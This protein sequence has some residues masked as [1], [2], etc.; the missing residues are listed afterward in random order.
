MIKH[1]GGGKHLKSSNF[2]FFIFVFEIIYK[3]KSGDRAECVKLLQN[4]PVLLNIKIC[5]ITAELW[6]I[7][8]FRIIIIMWQL[9]RFKS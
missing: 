2:F 4:F 9:N 1:W 3:I 7:N 6:S 5:W 8:C